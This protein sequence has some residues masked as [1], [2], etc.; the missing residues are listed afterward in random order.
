MRTSRILLTLFLAAIGLAGLAHADATVGRAAPPFQVSDTRGRKVDLAALKGKFVVLEWWNH[1]C[2][3]VQ[4]QYDSGKMQAQQKA[5]TGK[6]VVWIT[7][8]S[9]A[10]G[11]QG[12]VSAAEANRLMAE[13]K[14]APTHVVLDPSGTLGRLYGA[15]TTPHMFVIDSQGSL[16]YNGAI[17]DRGTTNYVQ[18]ALTEARAGRPVSRPVTRAYGCSVKYDH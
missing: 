12:H 3:F 2:P 9:S 11:Q 4:G 14:A 1:G 18:A 8:C 16:V 17:D 13:R 6:G 10:P 7:V 5:W 15:R